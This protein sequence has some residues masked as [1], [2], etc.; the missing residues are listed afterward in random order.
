LGTGIHELTI[1][2]AAVT[3]VDKAVFCIEE[4]EIHLHPEL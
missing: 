2:A 3:L 1:L 4:R